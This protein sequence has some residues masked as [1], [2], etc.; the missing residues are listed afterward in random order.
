MIRWG[1]LVGGPLIAVACYALLPAA[2]RDAHDNLVPFDTAGRA[3][4]SVM[5]WMALWWLSEAI[6]ISATALL[7]L[8]LFPLLGVGGIGTIA[9]PYANPLIFLFMGGFLLALSM[10][11]WGLDR[12]IA[13]LTLR[14]VGSRPGSMVAGRTHDASGSWVTRASVTHLRKTKLVWQSS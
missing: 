9:A 5:A 7:P 8:A 11:R 13:L 14:I 6:D 1:C 10:Q 3:T 12:R 4:L 2:Y